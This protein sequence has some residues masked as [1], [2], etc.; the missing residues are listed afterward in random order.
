M[1]PNQSL[2]ALPHDSAF[3]HLLIGSYRRL[4]GKS[5]VPDNRD[6]YWLYRDAPFVVVA[7]NSDPDPIFIYANMAAQRC[8]GYDWTEFMSLPSRLSAGPVHRADRQRLLERVKIDG[9]VVGYSGVRIAK[10]GARFSI[11]DGCVWQL[12][13]EDGSIKGQAAT[14]AMPG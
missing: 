13:E 7:H 11:D 6:Q 5:L 2:N 4:T 1:P 8:F 9:Y 12:I 14:F 3:F 10:S